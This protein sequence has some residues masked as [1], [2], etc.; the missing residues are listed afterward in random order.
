[1]SGSFRQSAQGFQ[2]LFALQR[3]GLGHGPA[4]NQLGE[5]GTGGDGGY[6]P[7]RAE[8]HLPDASI[9]EFYGQLHDVAADGML[10]AYLGVGVGQFAYVARVLE[11]VED[12]VGVTHRS[13]S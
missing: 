8:P 12:N 9:G 6:T 5:T 7:S 1:M 10:Q 2:E 13:S 11:V 4:G 3:G